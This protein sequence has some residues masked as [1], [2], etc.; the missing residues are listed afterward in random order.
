MWLRVSVFVALLAAIAYINFSPTPEASS[1]LNVLS[2]EIQAWRARGSIRTVL[3]RSVFVVQVPFK[4][5]VLSFL[6]Y[7]LR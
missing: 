1:D 5:M 4:G 3:G 2:P 7:R 6:A